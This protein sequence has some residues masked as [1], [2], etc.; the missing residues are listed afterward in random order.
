MESVVTS[1]AFLGKIRASPNPNFQHQPSVPSLP[2]PVKLDLMRS[3]LDSNRGT[4]R[5]EDLI[6]NDKIDDLFSKI[7]KPFEAAAGATQR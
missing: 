7:Q 1:V 2:R 5:K 4:D 6:K 3:R